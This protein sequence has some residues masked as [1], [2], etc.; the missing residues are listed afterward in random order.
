M[1]PVFC[2]L[3]LLFVAVNGMLLMGCLPRSATVAPRHFILSP[4]S[5]NEPTPAG[6]DL[7]VGIGFVKMPAYLL[8]SSMAVRNGANEIEYM[9]DALWGERLDQSFQRTL[10]ANLS[11]LLSSDNIYVSDSG[12][13]QGQARVFVNVQQFDVDK[14]GNG[15][16]IAQWR[17]TAPDGDNPLKS[18]QARLAQAGA[19]PRGNPQAIAS[20]LSALAGEFSREL[21]KPIRESVKSS[22]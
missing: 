22:P 19:A 15:T 4:I 17:I 20:T 11:R 5:T 10:A 18:G 21:V 14:D 1:K 6:A 16:L 13:N 3:P 12:R 9:K 8:R 2:L 7:T